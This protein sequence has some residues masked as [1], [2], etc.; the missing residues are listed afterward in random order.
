[1]AAVE[2]ARKAFPCHLTGK[3]NAGEQEHNPI[4]QLSTDGTVI[5]NG[6]FEERTEGT[7][8]DVKRVVEERVNNTVC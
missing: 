6:N 4:A 8:A 1:M 3:K 2:S 7:I 5:V